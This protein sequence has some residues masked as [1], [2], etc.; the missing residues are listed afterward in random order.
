MDVSSE[1]VFLGKNKG[2]LAADVT[3]GV[4]FLQKQKTIYMFRKCQGGCEILGIFHREVREVCAGTL[5]IQIYGNDEQ[6]SFF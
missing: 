1:P 2:G 4:I 6:T 3:S 5:S